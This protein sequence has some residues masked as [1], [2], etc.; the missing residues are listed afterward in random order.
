MIVPCSTAA[1]YVHLPWC[2]KKCP[3]CDFNS[4]EK[5]GVLAEHDYVD[6]LLADL[7]DELDWSAPPEITSVF[8]GGGTPS[9]FSA[10]AIGRL[11]DGFAKRLHFSADV[12]VTLEANPG[13][14]DEARFRG[15]RA[16]G[17][18]RLSIGVQSFDDTCLRQLGR[19]HD[20]QAAD[21]AIAAA[22]SAGFENFNLDLMYGLPAQGAGAVSDDLRRALASEPTHISWYQLTIEENTAFAKRPP[23]LPDPDL[24]DEQAHL[25]LDILAAYGF[26][27]YEVSAF[28]QPDR[29]CRHNLNYWEYGDYLGIGAGAHGKRTSSRGVTRSERVRNPARFINQQNP[30]RREAVDE[31]DLI[32]EFMINALRLKNGCALNLFEA[33][34]GLGREVLATHLATGRA[35]GWLA[36]DPIRIATTERGFRFL[37]DVQLLF[38]EG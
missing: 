31:S 21:S 1:L 17:V 33:R 32:A 30:V 34:T 15:Y 13:A 9:L 14:A 10:Q 38:L 35:R 6:A 4:Y 28:A 27:R 20:C 36:D 37:N 26:Q 29:A 8:F 16:A 23:A 3:Y 7:D 19:A 22:R 18:N 2:V 12:E 25:G 24:I 5:R 11:L